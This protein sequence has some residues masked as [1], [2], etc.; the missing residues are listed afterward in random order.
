MAHSRVIERNL[1][2]GYKQSLDS[3]QDHIHTFTNFPSLFL[4]LVN[5]EGGL[6]HYDGRV[7]VISPRR[8]IIADELDPQ[9][10]QSFIGEAVEPWTVLKFPY[11]LPMGYPDGMYRVGPLAR[12]NIARH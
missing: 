11:Y 9:D 10:Y 6:E 4:G 7:Q 5:A 2:C 12:L 8:S 3:Y 1:P